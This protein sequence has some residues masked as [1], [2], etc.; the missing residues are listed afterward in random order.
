MY[1]VNDYIVYKRNV[2]KIVDIKDNN[3]LKYYVLCPLDDSSLKI[4][5][6]INTSIVRPI[7]TEEEM[8]KL[9]KIMPSVSTIDVDDKLIEIEYKKLMASDDILDLVKIIKTTYLKN[10]ERLSKN[11]KVRD[12]DVY[13]FNKAERCLY[14][15]FSLVLNK[16]YDETKNYVI[17]EIENSLT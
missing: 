12:K 3:N 8:V 7:I 16:N 17:K 1:Q 4:Q 13:Y 11:R 15:E 5:I 2:C 10:Q 14:N 6:P 9:L